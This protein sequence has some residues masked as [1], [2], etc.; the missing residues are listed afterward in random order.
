MLWQL[1][2]EIRNAG[3]LP[4]KLTP[5]A[6]MMIDAVAGNVKW[7]MLSTAGGAT[8]VFKIRCMKTNSIDEYKLVM[9]GVRATTMESEIHQSVL[10]F[11]VC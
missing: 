7:E 6:L 5:N 1:D 4:T 3:E 9:T 8:V 2:D 11:I 10:E